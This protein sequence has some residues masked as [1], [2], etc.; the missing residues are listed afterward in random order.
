MKDQV[1]KMKNRVRKNFKDDRYNELLGFLDVENTVEA[2]YPAD[3]TT[4]GAVLVYY[5]AHTGEIACELITDMIGVI[6]EEE[7]EMKHQ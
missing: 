1:E 7:E 5:R 2:D 6:E 4:K 3:Y